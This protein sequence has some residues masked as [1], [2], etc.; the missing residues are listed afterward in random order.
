MGE[1]F[2]SALG[3]LCSSALPYQKKGGTNVPPFCCKLS[4]RSLRLEVLL[5]DFLEVFRHA[6][7]QSHVRFVQAL[8]RCDDTTDR[9]A[10]LDDHI[11]HIG[12]K[13]LIDLGRELQPVEAIVDLV[14]DG[15]VTLDLVLDLLGLAT[16]RGNDLLQRANFVERERDL[17]FHDLFLLSK[18]NLKCILYTLLHHYSIQL[19]ISTFTKKNRMW[20]YPYGYIQH[21]AVS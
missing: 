5:A 15:A 1:K 12:D 8:R 6:K 11:V 13:V 17:N 2:S 9:G 19:K 3:Q 4:T 21:C 14:R 10:V 20:I 16:E 7:V 18:H